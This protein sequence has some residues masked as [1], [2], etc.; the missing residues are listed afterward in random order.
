MTQAGRTGLRDF[1]NGS[2]G[3]GRISGCTVGAD[4]WTLDFLHVM[5]LEIQK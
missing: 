1:D 3:S 2:S 4:H 5:T